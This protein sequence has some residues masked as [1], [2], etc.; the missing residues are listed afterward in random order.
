MN[1]CNFIQQRL[2]ADDFKI[3]PH[4]QAVAVTSHFM[5][6]HKFILFSLL[7]LAACSTQN[8]KSKTESQQFSADSLNKDKNLTTAITNF[9][10]L[11]V[12]KKAAVFYSPDTTQIAKRKKEIGEENFYVGADDYLFSM[13]A[14]H[15]FLDSIKLTILNAKDKKYLKFIHSDKSQTIIKLDTLAELW[16]IYFFDPNKRQKLVDMTIIDEEYKSYF[17]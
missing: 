7:T 16:G 3:P 2:R 12:D 10:T 13:N 14:S 11:T 17:K 9:D 5:T 1:F 6:A 15:E 4:R 8:D